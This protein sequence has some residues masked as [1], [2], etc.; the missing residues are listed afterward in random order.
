MCCF[1]LI[2]YL[3]LFYFCVLRR[4]R[5]TGS[6]YVLRIYSYLPLVPMDPMIYGWPTTTWRKPAYD[7]PAWSWMDRL[8]EW[9]ERERKREESYLEWLGENENPK[10]GRNER[11]DQNRRQVFGERTRLSCYWYN[12]RCYL[13]T[14]SDSTP[15]ADST[16]KIKNKVSS[17]IL[18]LHLLFFSSFSH[19]W[20]L[21]YTI[22]KRGNDSKEERGRWSLCKL[23]G[24]R[25]VSYCLTG[26]WLK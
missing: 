15:H 13:Y 17:L 5:R 11:E 20:L 2:W 25:E 18:I 19:F 4:K 22:S 3:L 10:T 1:S 8:N 16:F 21:L 14:T 23:F 12:Y 26:W 24:G 9:R 6:R 7:R